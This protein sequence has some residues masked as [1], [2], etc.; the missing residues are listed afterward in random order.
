MVITEMEDTAKTYLDMKHGGEVGT[1]PAHLKDPYYKLTMDTVSIS[2]LSVLRT[3]NEPTAT[4][5]THELNKRGD[6]KQNF[7][8]QD[9]VTSATMGVLEKPRLASSVYIVTTGDGSK[10]E[11]LQEREVLLND[12]V[13]DTFVNDDTSEIKATTS[14][15]RVI[16]ILETGLWI[17]QCRISVE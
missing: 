14:D 8:I 5:I 16:Q 6:N 4:S 12:M 10:R 3:I 9:G 17:P 11:S 13:Y 1:V 2:G 15:S 7:L